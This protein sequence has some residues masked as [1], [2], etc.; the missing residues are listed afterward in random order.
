MLYNDPQTLTTKCMSYSCHLPVVKILLLQGVLTQGP[1][2]PAKGN[3]K[4]PTLALKDFHL[5]VT[6]VTHISLA[7]QASEL[8]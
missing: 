1:W 8:T 7:K 2:P 5:E 3:L 4:N 6:W